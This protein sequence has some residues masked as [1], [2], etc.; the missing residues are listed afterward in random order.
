MTKI[1]G[2][3]SDAFKNG[4]SIFQTICVSA[5]GSLETD[6]ISSISVYCIICIQPCGDAPRFFYKLFNFYQNF[7]EKHSLFTKGRLQI[8][9]NCAAPQKQGSREVCS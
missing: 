9:V 8:Y 1:H 7:D 3:S 4:R 5:G 2:G 6:N